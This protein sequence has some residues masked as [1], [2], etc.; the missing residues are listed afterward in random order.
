MAIEKK[1][2]KTDDIQEN[3]KKQKINNFLINYFYL[4]VYAVV[5]ATLASGYFL[6]ILPKYNQIMKDSEIESKMLEGEFSEQ[7]KSLIQMNDLRNRYEM[8]AKKDREKVQAMVPDEPQIENLISEMEMIAK[9]NGL[10]LSVLSVE[11]DNSTTKRSSLD[12]SSALGKKK[13]AGDTTPS[14]V[15][16]VNIEMQLVGTDYNNLRNVIKTVENNLRLLDIIK[17]SFE[18]A[19]T[20]TNLDMVAYYL[21]K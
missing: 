7:Q 20:K 12:P 19:N 8:I 6:F 4:V 2:I 5:I 16:K 17:I 21:K 10:I 3:I 13:E 18:A 1:Q 11:V 9:K 15:G 14:G